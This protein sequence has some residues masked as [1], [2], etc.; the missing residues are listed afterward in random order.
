MSTSHEPARSERRFFPGPRWIAVGFAFPVA[1]Y[2]GWKV[3]GHVDAVDA[4]LLGGVLT[5]AGLG[6]VEWW[7]AKGAFGRAEAWIG[8][9]AVGYAI[10]LTA[11]AALVGYDTDLSSL[12]VMGLVSGAGLGAGQ[13]LMLARQGRAFAL[14]W[15]AA[16]PVLFALG[17]C[18]STGIG[19]DVDDQFTVFGAAGA[20]VFT[21][22]S[23]LLLARFTPTRAQAA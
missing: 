17:W 10:G 8:S 19:I 12:A 5:G 18:A 14:R 20:L 13:G 1:G 3:G 6:A 11:G 7:A 16:M 23:G 21:L 4:A 9:S 2:I 15:A 22:L